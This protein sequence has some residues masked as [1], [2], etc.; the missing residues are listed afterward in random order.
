MPISASLPS[1]DGMTF[2]GILLDLGISSH[3]VDDA[4]RGF[5]FRPG[6]RLDMRMGSDAA[7]DAADAAEHGGRS[8]R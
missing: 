4:E 5:T 2:D 1:L 6:A 3:Q 8:R 7:R